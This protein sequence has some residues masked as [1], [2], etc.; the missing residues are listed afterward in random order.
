M[1]AGKYRR[2]DNLFVSEFIDIMGKIYNS[3]NI[4]SES[5]SEEEKYYNTYWYGNLMYEDKVYYS[6]N[7]DRRRIELNTYWYEDLYIVDFYI[8]EVL[9]KTYYKDS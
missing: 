9:Y 6:I 5:E 7:S 3:S 4:L 2:I 1:F 8:S